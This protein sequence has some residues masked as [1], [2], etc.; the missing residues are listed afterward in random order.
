MNIYHSQ[1]LDDS[2]ASAAMLSA[3]G[4][5][6]S[7]CGQPKADPAPTH[8]PENLSPSGPADIQAPTTGFGTP[9]K[10]QPSSTGCA[11]HEPFA[12]RQSGNV[13]QE[14]LDQNEKIIAWTTSLWV[15]QVICR[16]LNTHEELLD[17]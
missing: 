14:I 9:R 6:D 1:S 4:S 3:G 16:L 8:S 7:D 12:I 2:T 17:D 15:A 13:G 11:T 10:R 5:K